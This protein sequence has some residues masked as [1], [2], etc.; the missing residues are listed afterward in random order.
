MCPFC[1][2]TL[3][4]LVAGCLTAGALAALAVIP[5]KKISTLQRSAVRRL[6]RT[7]QRSFPGSELTRAPMD[8]GQHYRPGD[9]VNALLGFLYMTPPRDVSSSC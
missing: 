9:A 5:R 8:L 1:L 3:G 7:R 6:A 4:S 2:S